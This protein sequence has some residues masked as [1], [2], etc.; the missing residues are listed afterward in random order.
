MVEIIGYVLLVPA[1][2]A[3]SLFLLGFI[4]RKRIGHDLLGWH[5]CNADGFDGAS[6]TGTCKYCGQKCMQDSQGN[7][8]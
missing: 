6:V 5:D 1:I 8:F 7:W 4:F 3:F 2:G